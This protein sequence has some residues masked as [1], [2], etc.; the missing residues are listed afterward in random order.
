MGHAG[1]I[2]SG[3][4]GD[5]ETK[6]KTFKDCGIEVAVSPSDLGGAIERAIKGK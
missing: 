2:V 5:A 1:A 4:T 6:I 3:G